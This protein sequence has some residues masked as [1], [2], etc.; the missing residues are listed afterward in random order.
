MGLL[1]LPL[2]RNSLARVCLSHS[3]AAGSFNRSKDLQRPA[4]FDLVTP[5]E[6]H[7]H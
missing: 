2:L 7:R 3:P 1:C 5:N 6:A 4:V